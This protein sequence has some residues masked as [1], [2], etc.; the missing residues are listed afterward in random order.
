MDYHKPPLSPWG[1]HPPIPSPANHPG[2]IPST[3]PDPLLIVPYLNGLSQPPHSAH[4]ECQP[5]PSVHGECPPTNPAPT[6]PR[7]NPGTI[8]DPLNNCP[9]LS[10]LSSQPKG[11]PTNTPEHH[12]NRMWGCGAGTVP[13]FIAGWVVGG[14][15]VSIGLRGGWDSPSL[16]LR[17]SRTVTGFIPGWVGD[18]LGWWMP[19]L[20]GR[21][22]GIVQDD[23]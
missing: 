10:Q 16:L 11:T 12:P 8:P 2:I 6:Q 20:A 14:V 23:C 5:P 18:G 1:G 19:A 17:G 13:G 4:G 9:G 22:V 15:D 3:V 7:V 21:G